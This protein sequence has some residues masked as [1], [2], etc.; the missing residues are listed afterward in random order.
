MTVLWFS[1]YRYFS[2][3]HKLLSDQPQT[4]RPYCLTSFTPRSRRM[5]S[6]CSSDNVAEYHP[7]SSTPSLS[8]ITF[9]CSSMVCSAFSVTINRLGR[10]GVPSYGKNGATY[11]SGPCLSPFAEGVEPWFS[12][13]FWSAC[14]FGFAVDILWFWRKGQIAR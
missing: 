11:P 10:S 8:P 12:G 13:L 3:A 5:R 1:N 9:Q 7:P 6:I 2:I 4:A 14:S